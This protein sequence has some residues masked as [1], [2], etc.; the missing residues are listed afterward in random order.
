MDWN[1]PYNVAVITIPEIADGKKP[2]L[3]VTHDAGHGGWQF[4]PG[5]DISGIKP[6]AI[7]KE[8]ILRIDPSLE[9]ITDL[10]IGWRAVRETSKSEWVKELNPNR[11]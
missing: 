1:H 6:L 7:E 2:I 8:E 5:G 9:E 4:M 3:L 10:P 11:D